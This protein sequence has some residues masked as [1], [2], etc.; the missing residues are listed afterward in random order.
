M[1]PAWVGFTFMLIELYN[2]FFQ[3]ILGR[4]GHTQAEV[5]VPQPC[6][7]SPHPRPGEQARGPSWRWGCWGASCACWQW[8]EK[9]YLVEAQTG[10]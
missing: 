6:P 3:Y 4:K 1:N 8:W 5:Q 2:L 10:G 9:G 7:T